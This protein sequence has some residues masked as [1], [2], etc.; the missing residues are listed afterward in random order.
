[1]AWLTSMPVYSMSLTFLVIHAR[2]HVEH[3]RERQVVPAR[4]R[5]H[6]LGQV[7]VLLGP[8]DARLR[9]LVEAVVVSFVEAAI[10]VHVSSLA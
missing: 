2:A 5:E 6:V 1:M 7:R 4:E 3:A 9:V 10:L 8:V